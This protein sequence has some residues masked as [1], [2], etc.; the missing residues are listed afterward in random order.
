MPS[1]SWAQH[2]LMTAVEHS[3]S[4]ARKVGIPQSVGHEFAKADNKAGITKHPD[5]RMKAHR[6]AVKAGHT[7]PVSSSEFH[8][9]GA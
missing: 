8:R 3:P 2:K 7:H 5:R 9:F 1:K 6:D 4:F